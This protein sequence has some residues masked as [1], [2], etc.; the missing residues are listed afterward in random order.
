MAA[1][2][3]NFAG[4]VTILI[5]GRDR[6]AQAF[7]DHWDKTDPRLRRCAEASHSFVEPQGRIWLQE[8][9]LAAL[10]QLG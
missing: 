3:A 6:T 10:R 2:L 9:I 1:G 7:L 4:P 8:Q 5:A